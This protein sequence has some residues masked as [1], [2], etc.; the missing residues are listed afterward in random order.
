MKSL[1]AK[2]EL[3]ALGPGPS[4]WYPT[5][6]V[7][8]KDFP[9]FGL[10]NLTIGKEVVVEMRVCKVG[11]SI[12]PGGKKSDV[13]ITL[14]LRAMDVEDEV[15]KNIESARRKLMGYE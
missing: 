12:P 3:S 4:K 5:V 7:D 14:E 1:A 11:E 2:P 6:T 8:A 13:R 9:Q 15:P 10:K